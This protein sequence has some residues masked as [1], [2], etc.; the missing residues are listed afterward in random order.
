M[1]KQV[2]LNER[3]WTT[4]V[5]FEDGSLREIVQYDD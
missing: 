4:L 1:E 2:T 3:D 5:K